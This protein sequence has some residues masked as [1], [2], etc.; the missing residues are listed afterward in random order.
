MNTYWNS[1]F[2]FYFRELLE[3]RTENIQDCTQE[4]TQN[5]AKERRERK[6]KNIF[7]TDNL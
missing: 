1:S 5:L 6:Q 3:R 2:G 4:K 7:K